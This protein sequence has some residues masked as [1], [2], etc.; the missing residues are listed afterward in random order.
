MMLQGRSPAAR[1]YA[2][3]SGRE[4]LEHELEIIA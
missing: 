1:G 4:V 3:V 2:G